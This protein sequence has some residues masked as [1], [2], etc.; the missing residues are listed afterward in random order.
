ML[1]RIDG[2]PEDEILEMRKLLMDNAIDFYETDGGR[3]GTSV[4]GIWLRDDSQLETARTLIDNYQEERSERVRAEYALQ[5]ASGTAET[6]WSRLLHHPVRML[7]YLTIIL[8]ILYL[9]LM[10]FIGR[11]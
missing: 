7:V 6:M 3:W 2:A 4:S 5:E 8:A 10:P 11:W 9:T 1:I